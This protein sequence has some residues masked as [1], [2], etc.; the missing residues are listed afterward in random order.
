M[1][2]AL[3]QYRQLTA[4]VQNGRIPVLDGVRVLCVGLVAWFHIWQ[5]SWLT[6]SFPWFGRT[7][8]LDFLVRSG[9]IWVDGMLLLSGFLLYYPYAV[10][11][12]DAKR[13]PGIF[14]FYKKRAARI[15]PSYTLCVLVMLFFVAIPQGK[16]AALWD[17]ARDV[18][19]HLTF[20]H[21]LFPFSYYGSPL[22]GALWTLGVE[23]QF[24]LLFPFLARAFAKKPIITYAAMTCAAFAFRY[25]AST[26]PDCA[27]WFNQLPA[28]LDVYANGF[29]AASVFAA[30]AKK[31]EKPDK[32]EG[33]LRILFTCA[34]A[35]CVCC[36]VAIAK[37][38]AAENGTSAIRLGQMSRRYPLSV[39][40]GLLMVCLPFSVS[41]VRLIL[42]NAVTRVLSLCSFQFY[43][44]HQVL[45]VQL[46]A[47]RIP[48]S[49]YDNP[50]QMSDTTLWKYQFT[51]L[52]LAGALLLSALLT[53]LFERPLNRRLLKAWSRRK[54]TL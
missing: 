41:G 16:Y 50:N 20:T 12:R 37:G 4:P 24:Y 13:L 6:P 46:R 27:M 44:W 43:M 54:T 51:W 53:Y 10:S 22:N 33:W 11:L 18:L 31:L 35:A 2:K 28:F 32:A 5:Q 47:W 8:S 48:Y 9:Y 45:A 49:P 52:W 25:Y 19:A 36:L 34:C 40:L 15:V 30:I 17:G 26:L 23:V 29:V 14:G 7:V 42:G 39:M 1:E 21:T 38:Q 3:Y